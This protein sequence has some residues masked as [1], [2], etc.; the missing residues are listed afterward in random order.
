MLAALALLL[1]TT[2]VGPA[3]VEQW[4][5]L[6]KDGKDVEAVAAVRKQADRGDAEAL[7]F[8][9]W[10]Y[11][12]G[13]GVAKDPKRAAEIYQQAAEAGNKH[14]QWRYGVMLD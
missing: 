14:A 7:D 13:R 2:Q 8:L 5:M 6:L 9:G 10:F 1:A 3:E 4:R 11:D 12:T